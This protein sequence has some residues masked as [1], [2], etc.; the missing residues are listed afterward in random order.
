MSR[1]AWPNNRMQPTVPPPLRFGAPAADAERYAAGDA[2]WHSSRDG[3]HRPDADIHLQSELPH[4]PPR[5]N[6]LTWLR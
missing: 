4:Y 6:V 3:R 5:R 2:G 1:A